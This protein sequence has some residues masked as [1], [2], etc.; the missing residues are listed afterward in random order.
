MD[1]SPAN[2]ITHRVDGGRGGGGGIFKKS[3][4]VE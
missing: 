4:D 1:H 2:T 3:Y